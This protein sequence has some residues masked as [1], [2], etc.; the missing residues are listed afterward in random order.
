MKPPIVARIFTWLATA[1]APDER[2]RLDCRRP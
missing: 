2:A 1:I